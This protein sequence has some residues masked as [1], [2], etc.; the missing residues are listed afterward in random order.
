[1]MK[2]I[3]AEPTQD[4]KTAPAEISLAFLIDEW[5]SLVIASAKYSSAVLNDSATQ[6]ALMDSTS[7]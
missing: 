3:I 5:K 7:K 4:I 6:T 1:M 2:P